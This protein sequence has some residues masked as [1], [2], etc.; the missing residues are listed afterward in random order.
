MTPI[1]F[2]G[3][4]AALSSAH[5]WYELLVTLLCIGL[6]WAIDR[7]IERVR[8]RRVSAALLSGSFVRIAFPLLAVTLTYIASF[9]WRLYVGPPFFLAIAV[10]ILVALAII[11]MIVYALR[12]LFPSQSWLPTF[13]VAIG[14]TIWGLALLYFLGV[15]PEIGATLDELVIPLGKSQVSVLTIL[16]GIGVVLVTLVLT[17]WISGLIEQRLALATHLD[18]N[19]RVVLSRLVKG[20][21]IVV[22]VLIAL[23]Q[24]GFDLTLLAVFGGALM[25]G[26]GLGLQK[27]ASNYIAGFTILLDRSIR[28]GDM[29]TVD[30]RTGIVSKVTARYVV[31][32]NVDGLEAIVPNETLISTTVMNHSHLTT[33]HEVRIAL[34]VQVAYETDVERAL[35]LL[36]DIA[37]REPRVLRDGRVPTAYV[38]NLADS[39]ITLELAVWVNDPKSG[40]LNVKSALYLAILKEFAANHIQIPFPRRD[41]HV[42]G[43]LAAGTDESGKAA[44]DDVRATPADGR[45]TG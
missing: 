34:S 44:A 25:V 18:A 4:Q 42:T 10:P 13:E 8:A 37:V 33:T 36:R 16:T 9:A 40:H 23:Q 6:A 31:V 7:R 12:R 27:L 24:I 41:V 38:V 32:R 20:L 30:N 2:S 39:G 35:Q 28:L 22:G 26:V 17:L 14:T 5:G 19:L 3:L 45:A 29:V 21:L 1:D 43:T 15:L 11:R